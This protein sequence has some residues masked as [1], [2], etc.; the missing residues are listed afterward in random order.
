MELEA[1]EREAEQDG[2]RYIEADS[3]EDDND[4]FDVEEISMVSKNSDHISMCNFY[5]KNYY[6]G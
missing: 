4:D 5:T 2:P 1:D 6:S 3:D